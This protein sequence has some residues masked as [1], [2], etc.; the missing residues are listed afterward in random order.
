MS[1]AVII[2]FAPKTVEAKAAVA[3]YQHAYDVS[4]KT[5][6][7]A[8]TVTQ[9]G[10]AVAGVLWVCALIAY[11]AIPRERS[12]FPVVTSILVGVALWI[13]LVSQVVRR[14]FLVQGQLLESVT[15]SAVAVSPLLSHPQRIEAM[16]LLRPPALVGWQCSRVRD[17]ALSAQHRSAPR[18]RAVGSGGSHESP[19]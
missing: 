9:G 8:E 6:A 11:Q 2:P 4:Q 14:G 3:R 19:R 7:F 15:D 16:A 12:G 5:S 17:R 13:L 10:I 18:I 1:A